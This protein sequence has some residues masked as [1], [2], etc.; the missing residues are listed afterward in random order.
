MNFRLA[1]ILVIGLVAMLA[2]TTTAS[3]QSEDMPPSAPRSL[4]VAADVGC[5][6]FFLDWTES[7]DDIDPRWAIRYDV[8]M[9]IDNPEDAGL[10]GSVTGDYFIELHV[11]GLDPDTTY[12]FFLIAVD[13]SD[14]ASEESNHHSDEN[15]CP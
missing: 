1:V 4:F 5:G 6:N 9:Y 12:T 2:G 13:S 14:N 15:T 3:A 11:P 7:R 10:V 8:Y